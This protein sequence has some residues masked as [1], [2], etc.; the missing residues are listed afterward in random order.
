M[1]ATLPPP[2]FAPFGIVHAAMLGSMALA[3]WAWVAWARRA[4][5]ARRRHVEEMVAYAN[6]ALWIVIR[7]YLLTPDQF[8]WSVWIPLGMCDIMTLLVS[9]RLLVPDTRWFSIALYFG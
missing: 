5:N 1:T 4:G 2:A 7:L 9:V 6:L 3:A 8:R